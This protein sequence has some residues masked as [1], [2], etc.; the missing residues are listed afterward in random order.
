MLLQAAV[1]YHPVKL[2][3]VPKQARIKRMGLT[4]L[5]MLFFCS[6]LLLDKKVIIFKTNLFHRHSSLVLPMMSLTY[7][8]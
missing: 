6:D 2:N 3:D 8:Y 4:F 1:L 5:F 7:N